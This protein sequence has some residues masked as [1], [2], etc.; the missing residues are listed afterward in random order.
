MEEG[1]VKVLRLPPVIAKPQAPEYGMLDVLPPAEQQRKYEFWDLLAWGSSHFFVAQQ[2]LLVALADLEAVSHAI[3]AQLL[4]CLS[5]A[6]DDF[7]VGPRL[8]C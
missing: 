1:R 8:K 7:K 5:E 6:T 2:R 4:W 3:Q